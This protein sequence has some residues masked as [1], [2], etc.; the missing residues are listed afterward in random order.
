[1]IQSSGLVVAFKPVGSWGPGP[2]ESGLTRF[3]WCIHNIHKLHEMI[4]SCRKWLKV[5]AAKGRSELISH[6]FFHQSLYFLIRKKNFLLKRSQSV[7]LQIPAS[8]DWGQSGVPPVLTPAISDP[9]VP[10][11]F[12]EF[13]RVTISG[14]YCAGVR[15]HQSSDAPWHDAGSLQ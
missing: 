15:Y 7:S 11:S 6:D 1:M 12:P 10:D 13:Q 8:I 4:K 2:G 3:K 14:D 9:S 5:L